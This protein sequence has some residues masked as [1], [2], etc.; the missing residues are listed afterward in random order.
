MSD[1]RDLG[2]SKYINKEKKQNVQ[3][4]FMTG[5]NL[6]LGLKKK[7]VLYFDIKVWDYYIIKVLKSNYC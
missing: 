5:V 2:K 6:K 4:L 7:T 3:S 1:F